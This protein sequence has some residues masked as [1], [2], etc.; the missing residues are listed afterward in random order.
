M[1]CTDGGGA[2]E[3]DVPRVL[4][5]VPNRKEASRDAQARWLFV[6]SPHRLTRDW[7]VSPKGR[8]LVQTVASSERARAGRGL[9]QRDYIALH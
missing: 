1:N 6:G 2:T 5:T 4:M 8:R 9:V 7:F 3:A